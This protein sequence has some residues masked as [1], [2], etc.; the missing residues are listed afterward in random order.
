M[1]IH[2][3]KSS[4]LFH[5]LPIALQQPVCPAF[6]RLDLLVGILCRRRTSPGG[7]P[8]SARMPRSTD[9]MLSTALPVGVRSKDIEPFMAPKFEDNVIL[10]KTGAAD[11][12]QPSEESCSMPEIR[13]F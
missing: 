10:T 9:T 12:E 3:R 1:Q 7:L 13:M 5:A 2:L 6:T 11:D 8:E 4:A